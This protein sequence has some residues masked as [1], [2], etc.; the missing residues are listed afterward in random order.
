MVST[1]GVFG[2][3]DEP[4]LA[5]F[6]VSVELTGTDTDRFGTTPPPRG[7]IAWISFRRNPRDF[8]YYVASQ[9]QSCDL[10]T[11]L[12]QKWLR[13]TSLRKCQRQSH[14]VDQKQ[15]LLTVARFVFT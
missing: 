11:Y 3:T 6:V 15:I 5:T 14:I 2:T 4:G 1:R 10:P 13:R 9:T 7:G 12:E 8:A